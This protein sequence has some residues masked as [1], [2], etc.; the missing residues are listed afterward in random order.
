MPY[1]Q[2]GEGAFA[3]PVAGV[4]RGGGAARY[5]QRGGHETSTGWWFYLPLL[6]RLLKSWSALSDLE[7]LK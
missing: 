6:V 7:K 1:R 3:S 4:G 5:E 2:P